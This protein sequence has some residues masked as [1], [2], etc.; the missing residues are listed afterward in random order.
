MQEPKPN[1]SWEPLGANT[2][3][4]VS[5]EH[6][7]CTDTVLLAHFSM[8]RP[9][10]LCVDL[11]TGCGTIPILWSMHSKPDKIYGVEI[12]P[13]AAEMAAESVQRN[14]LTDRIMIIQ[15]DLTDWPA[16]RQKLAPAEAGSFHLVSCNPPYTALGDGI[17]SAVEPQATARHEFRCSF[18][19]V[20]TT[21]ERLLR[22][23]GRFCF[24]LRPER[25]SEA[26]ETVRRHG[27]EPKRLR[28]VQQRP[29]KPPFLFLMQAVRGGKTGIS[30]DP[31]LF[32]E[33]PG[34][35]SGKL[36]REMLAIYGD[37]KE[38]HEQ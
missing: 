7:F 24:C 34:D 14:R 1:C 27:M 30:V 8:P 19:D 25:L 29:S 5:T 12:Q 21:A 16:L 18:E 37:Y 15:Q 31:V 2:Q 4:L 9:H 35:L 36:S 10:E 13:D 32:I 11:G 3:I 17:A 38:G 6:R 33:E 28:F 20:A 23:G 22:W 26:C